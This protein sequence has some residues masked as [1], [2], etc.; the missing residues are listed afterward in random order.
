MRSSIRRYQFSYI[1]DFESQFAA[2]QHK[3][4]QCWYLYWYLRIPIHFKRSRATP[5]QAE[6]VELTIAFSD[7]NFIK[8]KHLGRNLFHAS[9]PCEGLTI[10]SGNRSLLFL[11][12]MSCH[13]LIVPSLRSALRH[14]EGSSGEGL[15]MCQAPPGSGGKPEPV[16]TRLG[17]IQ[18]YRFNMI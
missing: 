2:G 18:W 8:T 7:R 11:M 15:I 10:G 12:F 4:H 3:G 17:L 1:Q 14:R 5:S 13:L 9:M 6:P 16:E